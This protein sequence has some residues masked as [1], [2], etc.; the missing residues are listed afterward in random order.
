MSK[1]IKLEKKE[2]AKS[3]QEKF[4]AIKSGT[5]FVSSD[6]LKKIQA[7]IAKMEEKPVKAKKAEKAPEP[8]AEPE[9]E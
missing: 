3:L 9:A 5:A 1:A 4:E 7:E 6:E 2:S 8:E